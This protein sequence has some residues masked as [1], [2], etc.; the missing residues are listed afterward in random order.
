MSD[1]GKKKE[2]F[3]IGELT[4]DDRDTRDTDIQL[5]TYEIPLRQPEKLC[6]AS[7]TS[8]IEFRSI[9]DTDYTFISLV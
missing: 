6:F 2:I 3:L 5:T 1:T 7:R 9:S 8:L 4:R